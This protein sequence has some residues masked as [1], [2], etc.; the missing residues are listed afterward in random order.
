MSRRTLP[1]RSEGRGRPDRRAEPR[2]AAALPALDRPRQPADRRA[3]EVL[4][5]KRIE[6]GDMDAKQQMIEANLR[7]GGVDRQGLP[8]AR[9]DLPGPD[10]GGL[11]GADPRGREVR[12][13]PRLQVLHLRDLVDPP[14]CHAG[15]RRQGAHD[16][17]P[18]PHGGEAGTR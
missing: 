16:P 4:L 12:L 3:E 7:L 9:A 8:R 5:A 15:D 10:P 13:P 18:R 17:D 1:Q 14:G 11:D 6:R 2:F